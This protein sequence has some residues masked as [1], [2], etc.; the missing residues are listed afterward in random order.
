M[1]RS[2][3]WAALCLLFAAASAAADSQLASTIKAGDRQNAMAMI[4]AGADVN[5][6]QPDG[7]T[8]LHWAVYRQDAELVRTLLAHG[9]N[10]KVVNTFGSTPLAEAIKVT[11]LDLA[12]MLLKAGAD[13]ESAND[14][15]ETALMLAARNGS[16]PI[17]ALLVRHGA[18]VNARERWRGQTALMWA[19]A[20]RQPEVIEL[21]LAHG[22]QVNAR[23]FATDWGNQIT[24]EPRAQYRPTGGLTPLLYAARSGCERCAQAMLKAG[25]DINLPN[26]DGI[27]PLMTA[28][29]NLHFDLAK[30]LL[31]RGANPHTWDW[32]GR[33]PLYV[34]VD[35]HSY[36]NSR[37]SFNGPRVRVELT[38]KTT[39]LDVIKLLLAAGVNP[40][41]QLDMHRPGRGG[42]SARF[43]ENLLTTGATPLLRA[44]IAQDPEACQA[45]LEHGALVDLPNAMG[46][47]PLMA[48]AGIGISTNDP[49]PL[50]D[51][52]MQSRALATLEVLVKAGADVNARILDT[53]SHTA[54][55][56]RPSTMTDRQ[57][58]T[59]I[60]GPITWSWT[61]VAQFLIDH[62]ARVDVVDAAGKT[63]LN[64]LTS[65]IARRDAKAAEEMTAL[66]KS[67]SAASKR[68]STAHVAPSG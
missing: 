8:A 34:A 21:L 1:R 38:D 4:A 11:N 48:A 45:L 68:E 12:A 43:V 59:A 47:T 25:A 35:M 14:D 32:W 28:I 7:T 51:D 16:L 20:E 65:D 55:I 50:F 61:R 3:S 23:A 24:S 22:A 10:P 67:A 49:R 18:K 54:R 53:S 19:A 36:P 31:E 57:G 15:G 40:N 33:T 9:A 26:P 42:N 60:Y 37:G 58:Q 56:A 39:A 5:A 27:T 52:D 46:V 6:A 29:D 64:T 44:A 30:H 63:P 2:I 13:V 17:A 62:G 41:P 66:I